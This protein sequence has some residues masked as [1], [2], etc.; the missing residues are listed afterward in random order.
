MPKQRAGGPEYF[1]GQ[2]RSDAPVVRAFCS[3]D[4]ELKRKSPLMDG[5]RTIFKTKPQIF[6]L[7]ARDCCKDPIAQD[8]MNAGLCPFDCGARIA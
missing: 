2:A 1:G 3:T 8:W 6:A 4:T 7:P 5:A